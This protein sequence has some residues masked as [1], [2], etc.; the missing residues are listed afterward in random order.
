MGKRELAR[1]TRS[2]RLE[3]EAAV[4]AAERI[5]RGKRIHRGRSKTPEETASQR[6]APDASTT[7]VELPFLR[8][9]WAAHGST[10]AGAAS[11]AA[12]GDGSVVEIEPSE[13]KYLGA[14]MR[15]TLVGRATR[16]LRGGGVRYQNVC[17][18][19]S[20]GWAGGGCVLAL[21]LN[22][23]SDRQKLTQ[24]GS[25]TRLLTAVQ[26][27]G[28]PRARWFWVKRHTAVSKVCLRCSE[29]HSRAPSA[30]PRCTR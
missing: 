1:R 9:L 24:C 22:P 4:K 14:S 21:T 15:Q 10:T 13:L 16:R 17:L 5:A 30:L 25:P 29:H 19:R 6:Q 28:A 2:V 3:W 8:F 27:F 23:P 12:G 18:L 26:A 7:L 20:H 11:T